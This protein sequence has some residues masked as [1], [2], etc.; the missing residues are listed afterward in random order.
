MVKIIKHPLIEIKLTKIRD[1]NT[2]HTTFRKNLNEIAS[3]MVYEI[4][5]NYKGKEEIVISPTGT[6]TKGLT[7]DSEIVIIPILRAGLGMVHGIEELIPQ[8]RIGHIGVYR[9]ETTFQA[10]SYFFKIPNV[11][12]NSEIIIIDPMLAT[13]NSARFAIEQLVKH[14]F[15]K[16]KLVCLV[17]VS[18]GIENVERAYSKIEIYLAAKDQRLDQNKYIIPGLGDAGDRLFG[19]K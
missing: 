14:G 18:E 17:G 16:I 9:D 8:A 7:F 10:N 3:L 12:K 13:G 15:T 11:S 4:L 6:K 19:T 2:L 1:K 5:R